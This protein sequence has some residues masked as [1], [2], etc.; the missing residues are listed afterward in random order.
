MVDMPCQ[1]RLDKISIITIAQFKGMA[2][3]QG[4]KLLNSVMLQRT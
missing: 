2:D 4:A 1:D 3:Y